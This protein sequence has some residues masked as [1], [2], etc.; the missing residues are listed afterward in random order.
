MLSEIFLACQSSAD[1]SKDLP[2]IAQ[3]GLGNM[4]VQGHHRA[5]MQDSF[6]L[7][8]LL[9]MHFCQRGNGLNESDFFS[10]KYDDVTGHLIKV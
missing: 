9:C 5:V 2:Q 3:K 4:R 8:M 10:G 6:V 7:I 1:G